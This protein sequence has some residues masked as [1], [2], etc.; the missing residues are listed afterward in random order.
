MACLKKSSMKKTLVCKKKTKTLNVGSV[1][2][3]I[4]VLLTQSISRIQWL[5]KFDE[6]VIYIFFNRFFRH[7]Q[8]TL[9][10]LYIKFDVPYQLRAKAFVARNRPW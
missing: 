8:L 3:L 6:F 5:S 1:M 10:E 2:L 4:T 9:Q 7:W